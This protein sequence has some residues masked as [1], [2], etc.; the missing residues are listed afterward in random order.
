MFMRI[1]GMA[2]KFY[3]MAGEGPPP[4]SFFVAG[5]Q[6]VGGGPSPAMT[7]GGNRTPC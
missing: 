2:T 7:R 1:T 6:V 5:S 4:T 3:V